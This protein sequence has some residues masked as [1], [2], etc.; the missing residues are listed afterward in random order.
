[1]CI[2][3]HMPVLRVLPSQRPSLFQLSALTCLCVRQ[4]DRRPHEL[5]VSSTDSLIKILPSV[6]A[7]TSIKGH[8]FCIC[9]LFQTRWL[10]LDAPVLHVWMVTLSANHK[11]QLLWPGGEG[12]SCNAPCHGQE[13]ELHA[14]WRSCDAAAAGSHDHWIRSASRSWVLRSDQN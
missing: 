1:M 10:V 6:Y 5:S 3:I 12:F 2:D 13:E 8:C 4:D 11:A 7:F 14:L 9:F